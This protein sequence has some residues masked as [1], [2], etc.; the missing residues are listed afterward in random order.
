MIMIVLL[1]TIHHTLKINNTYTGSK[2]LDK[3]IKRDNYSEFS[4]GKRYEI[5]PDYGN[6]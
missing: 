4:G 3:T 5:R 1:I 6:S 2:N